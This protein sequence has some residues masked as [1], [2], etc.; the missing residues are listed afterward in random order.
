MHKSLEMKANETAGSREVARA[1]SKLGAARSKHNRK[2]LVR[3]HKDYEA[4]SKESIF[5]DDLE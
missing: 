2:F 4:P 5:S 3:D 1:L